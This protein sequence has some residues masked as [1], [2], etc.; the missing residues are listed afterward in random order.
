MRNDKFQI[1]SGEYKQITAYD[2]RCYVSD[3]G[4]SDTS[5]VRCECNIVDT[6]DQVSC[7]VR[8]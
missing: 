8:H 2:C 1:R 4:S 3:V 5:N 6:C 7:F